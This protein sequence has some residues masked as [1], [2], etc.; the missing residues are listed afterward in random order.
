MG[1]VSCSAK[2]SF[3]HT[4]AAEMENVFPSAS[5]LG[6][7]S[8]YRT[9]WSVSKLPR[10]LIAIL[11]FRRGVPGDD[12]RYGDGRDGD[13]ADADRAVIVGVEGVVR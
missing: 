12:R 13:D 8:S 2:N 3:E 10:Y 9:L 4:S 1:K 5:K 11:L 7:S 6:L